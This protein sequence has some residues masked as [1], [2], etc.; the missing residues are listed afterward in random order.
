MQ[1]MTAF[2]LND[3][4][5]GT[6]AAG[7]VPVPQIAPDEL[8]VK[9]AATGVGI[10]DSYFLPA[11]MR[12]PYPIGIE[13]AGI[14]EQIGRDVLGYVPGDRIAFVSMRQA[15]GGVWAEYAAVASD[16]L[17]V[18]IP[19]GLSFEEA[20]AVPVAGNTTSRALHSLPPIASGGSIFIAG[21][22]GAIGTFALQLACARGWR[23]AASASPPN[24]DYLRSLGAEL[25]VDYR[26]PTW[27]EKVRQ[28][29]PDGVEGALAVQPQT[30][31]DAALTVRSGGTVVTVSGDQ[32]APPG[33][34]VTGLDY[35][36]N[37]REELVALMDDIVAGDLRLV[38]E[39]TYP[40]ADA[41][42]A[43]D[44]TQT[45][46]ARGKLVVTLGQ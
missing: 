31:E 43:L 35:Q 27:P 41:L 3:P 28:W 6:I 46:H 22:S 29:R 44:K 7:R 45:R 9:V 2:V 13:A 39:K 14:V 10:H 37:V 24:H 25:A 21:G 4:H 15:K 32:A 26:D 18:P 11:E 36:V 5:S 34:R 12:F 19:E 40:F 42:S 33:I 17:I 38:I 16:S 8:L 23:V 20:A 30:T 1:Y